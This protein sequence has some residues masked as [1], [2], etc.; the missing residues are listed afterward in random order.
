MRRDNTHP[1]VYIAI[2]AAI[3]GGFLLLALGD[4]AP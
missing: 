4:L 3:I 1:I 2:A